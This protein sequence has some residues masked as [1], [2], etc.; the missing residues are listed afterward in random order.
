MA[1]WFPALTLASTELV[2]P[3]PQRPAPLPLQAPSLRYAHTHAIKIKARSLFSGCFLCRRSCHMTQCRSVLY[4]PAVLHGW[5]DYAVCFPSF[6]CR[7]PV[8]N[9]HMRVSGLWLSGL[10]TGG[11]R[12]R[13]MWSFA[14]KP[15]A[16]SKLSHC[17]SSL[18][19]Q[20]WDL[21]IELF[22]FL[23]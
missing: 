3:A 23:G 4:G 2:A 1:A 15:C 18:L 7:E 9:E 12:C 17:G 19:L 10:P 21:S 6:T 20:K 14:F 5:T 8:V 16:A 22:Y 13:V 11:Y